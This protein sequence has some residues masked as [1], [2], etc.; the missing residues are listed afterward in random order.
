MPTKNNHSM[1]IT[2]A[3]PAQRNEDALIKT[4]GRPGHRRY[5]P[6]DLRRAAVSRKHVGQ[7]EADGGEDNDYI[8]SDRRTAITYGR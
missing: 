4:S 3:R 6:H 2:P 1:G 8:H 7:A 5:Q